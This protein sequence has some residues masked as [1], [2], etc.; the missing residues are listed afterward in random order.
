[1]GL[2]MDVTDR[3]SIAEGVRAIE[4]AWGGIDVLV[5]NAGVFGMAPVEEITPEDYRRQYDVNV[6][7][8]IFAT[9]AVVAGMK[10]RGQ[11]GRRSSTSPPRRA[12]G[13]RPTWRST[14]RPRRR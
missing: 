8:T 13:G 12:G 7:G 14:A 4:E 10:A 2:R 11:G 1:M 6:G 5:N 9:Q 3:A